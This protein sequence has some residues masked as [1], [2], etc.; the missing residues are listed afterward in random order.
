MVNYKLK[1]LGYRK[2]L[3]SCNK[4]ICRVSA[5]I[6][7]VHSETNHFLVADRTQQLRARRSDC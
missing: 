2:Y 1:F 6:L 7:M 3:F 5:E 4:V